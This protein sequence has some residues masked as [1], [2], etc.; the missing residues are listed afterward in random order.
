MRH[1]KLRFWITACLLSASVPA[2]AEGVALAGGEAS[3]DSAYAYM[4]WIGPL[5][6]S[7]NLS[8]GFFYRLWLDWLKY[9]FDG[10]AGNVE[11][12]A[13]GGE[14]ALGH[15]WKVGS[16]GLGASVGAVYRNTALDPSSASS[17][18]KGDRVGVKLQASGHQQG[19]IL[20][21]EGIASYTVGPDS[22]WGRMRLFETAGGGPWP[23]VEVIVQGSP[24]Y[25]A[26]QVGGVLGRI[27]LGGGRDLN[28]KAG[29]RLQEGES[30]ASYAG[31][32]LAWVF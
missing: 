14:V 26:V 27:G 18:V 1:P 5:P 31:L 6:T 16:G 3:R 8:E 17:E 15:N 19:E 7:S 32:E 22:Y 28:L 25:D 23:G 4:G 12:R 9:E 29:V 20:R 13:P 2:A 10:A 30:A 11:A 24:D 21:V